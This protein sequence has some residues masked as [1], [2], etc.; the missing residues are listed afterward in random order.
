MFSEAVVHPR[1]MPAFSGETDDDPSVDAAEERAIAAVLRELGV[2][3]AE[4]ARALERGD[5]EEA[6]I[7]ALLAPGRAERTVSFAEVEARGGLPA[8]EIAEIFRGMGL[9][10]LAADQPALTPEEAEA[11]TELGRLSEIW[12]RELNRQTS[13]IW[14]RLVAR[15]ARAGVQMF[16]LYSEP[17][18]ERRGEDRATQLRAL[19][20]GFERL[21][22]LP[23]PIL[24]G[25]HRRW[26][27][28]EL[29]QTATT[30]AER[31]APERARAGAV[32]VTLLFCDLKDFTAYADAEGDAAA[33]EA[34]TDFSRVVD[35]SRGADG[36]LLKALGDGHMLAYSAPGAAVEAGAR[37]IA[38][39]RD[40]GPLG[41]H[42]SV[43]RGIAIAHE[44]DYFGGTVN[45]AARLLA[46]ANRDELVA[47]RPVVEGS[48]ERFAWRALGTRSV[49]GVDEPVA[50]FLLEAGAGT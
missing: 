10:P 41:V 13:R 50:V 46:A 35:D 19:A 31:R 14:G 36:R 37:I 40:T 38:A 20:E 9:M 11:F 34:I 32:D 16:R 22:T 25:A 3:E 18:L 8:E 26:V 29:T 43:H 6:V 24:A 27:E 1:Q 42:A 47:T 12:P 2:P 4:V 49:R 7:Q 44:G 39:M 21:L 33:V 48:G 45:L 5:P 15:I 28:Y 17:A 23:T 30:D